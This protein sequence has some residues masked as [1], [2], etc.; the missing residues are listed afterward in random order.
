M[1]NR[2]NVNGQKVRRAVMASGFTKE[3]VVAS[4]QDAGFRFSLAGL[5]KIYR[6]ELPVRDAED[7]LGAIA[8]KC[9]CQT[10][11]FAESE[12]RTA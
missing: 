10:S 4:V 8:L 3:Q 1:K 7:I 11:D 9:G 12:A 2:L 5:D 6:G